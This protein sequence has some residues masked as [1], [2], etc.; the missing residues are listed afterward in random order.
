MPIGYLGI[1]IA[2]T[3]QAP[4]FFDVD[5]TNRILAA[6]TGGILFASVSQLQT[7][8]P[9]TMALFVGSPSTAANPN[10]GPISGGT[11]VQFIPAPNGAGSAD[12]IVASMQAY[13]GAT[14]ATQ[15]VVSPYPASSEGG[16]FLTATAP[17]AITSGP[18]SVLLTDANNNAVFLPDAYT[19]GPHVLRITPNVVSLQGGDHITISGYGL[20]FNNPG[21][22]NVTIGG[23]RAPVISLN[24]YGAGYPEETVTVQVPPGT[25]GWADL[26]VST[27]N[28]ADTVARGVQYLAQT[29]DVSGGPFTFAVYDS[30][31][32]RFY[33]TGANNA[34]GVFD[35]GTVSLLQPLQSAT[36]S[37]GAVLAGM[38]LTP[39]NSKLLVSDPTDHSVVIFDLVGGTNSSVD[40]LLPSD[41]AVTLFAP[42]SIV[43]TSG[44]H[45]FVSLTPCI[46]N[47]VREID[48]TTSTVQARTDAASSCSPGIY[49]QLDPQV[50]T[51]AL[52]FL[53]SLTPPRG[54]L[55]YGATTQ[56]PT[57]SPVRLP[58][59]TIRGMVGR[60]LLVGMETFSH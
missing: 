39:D 58:S 50:V 19:Y 29:A 25:P 44:N 41:P 5:E 6:V 46:P 14:P 7:V 43:A 10:V 38:A 32:D 49:P 36:V 35:P 24:P 2:A 20:P 51:G 59:M 17:P 12:G 23:S 16:N 37:S 3:F 56:H 34:V 40:V 54:P 31:R 28:G 11:E 45:A 18:V 30:T 53:V 27:A 15:D 48:L 4:T 60:Q 42:M 8:P 13:F 26:K 22:A 55:T 57:C 47:P 33:L 52:L 9:A 1:S 21:A